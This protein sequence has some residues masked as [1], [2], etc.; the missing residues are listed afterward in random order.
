MPV[1]KCLLN[2]RNATHL[3]VDSKVRGFPGS[4]NQS[5]IWGC[6]LWH[7]VISNVDIRRYSE[8][9]EPESWPKK[10]LTSSQYSL[11]IIR[12]ELKLHTH[13]VM[14]S[15]LHCVLY[16][17]WLGYPYIKSFVCNWWK[18]NIFRFTVRFSLPSFY[19]CV[20]SFMPQRLHPLGSMPTTFQRPQSHGPVRT[21][22]TA[23]YRLSEGQYEPNVPLFRLW[24]E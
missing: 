15:F 2:G 10:K 13:T 21:V 4:H 22:M 1:H 6:F 9:Q 12:S 16:C 7:D 24:K 23:P 17:L 20:Y 14:G 5:T 18:P 3:T 11:E 19:L 8:V